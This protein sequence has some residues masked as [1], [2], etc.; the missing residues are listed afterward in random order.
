MDLALTHAPLTLWGH[1][2]SWDYWVK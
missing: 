2:C 1:L